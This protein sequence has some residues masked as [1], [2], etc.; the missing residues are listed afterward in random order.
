MIVCCLSRRSKSAAN[1]SKATL[2]QVATMNCG[3]FYPFSRRALT[4]LANH[5]PRYDAQA[6]ML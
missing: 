1:C 6:L 2:G 5:Q 3:D 4:Y